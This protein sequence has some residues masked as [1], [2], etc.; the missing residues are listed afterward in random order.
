MEAYDA[1][2]NKFI[3]YKLKFFAWLEEIW[4]SVYRIINDVLAGIIGF[5]KELIGGLWR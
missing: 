2:Q 1:K 3:E 5:I 4:P